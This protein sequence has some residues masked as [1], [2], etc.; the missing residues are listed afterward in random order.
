MGDSMRR[1]RARWGRA[2]AKSG[3]QEQGQVLVTASLCRMSY[4]VWAP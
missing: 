4:F 2:E 1:L 3:G